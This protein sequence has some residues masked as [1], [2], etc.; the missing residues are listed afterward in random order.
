MAVGPPSSLVCAE[1]ASTWQLWH[2]ALEANLDAHNSELSTVARIA[3]A[4][5]ALLDRMREGGYE[6]SGK[7]T[8]DVS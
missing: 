5:N 6:V 8:V 7:I 2:P 1:R 3:G 4:L